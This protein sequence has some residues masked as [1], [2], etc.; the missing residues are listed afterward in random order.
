MKIR[1][2]T[3][4]IQDT[5]LNI[6]IIDRDFISYGFFDKDSIKQSKHINDTIDNINVQYIKGKRLLVI[7]KK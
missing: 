4:L 7:A 5:K 3:K 6:E 2:I 1:D